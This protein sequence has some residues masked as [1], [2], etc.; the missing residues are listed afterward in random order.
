[1]PAT[2]ADPNRSLDSEQI[3]PATIAH[4]TVYEKTPNLHQSHICQW[5][6]QPYLVG[7]L[8]RLVGKPPLSPWVSADFL[9]LTQVVN[10]TNSAIPLTEIFDRVFSYVCNS[11]GF[12]VQKQKKRGSGNNRVY[13]N[14]N[15]N[16]N[17]RKTNQLGE[18]AGERLF[19]VHGLSERTTVQTSS[20]LLRLFFF[21]LL[22]NPTQPDPTRSISLTLTQ[23][24]TPADRV[25]PIHSWRPLGPS[26]VWA[27]FVCVSGS[28]L[29]L[30]RTQYKK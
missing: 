27:D 9:P 11:L 16:N 12:E 5:G 6:A 29:Y 1:M 14:L 22:A 13:R 30:V 24:P 15:N 18:V 21:Y 26:T 25:V 8:S 3:S 23:T 7:P 2:V 28:V 17:N 19:A 4:H 10:N 20:L